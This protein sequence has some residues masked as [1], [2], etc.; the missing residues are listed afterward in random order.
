MKCKLSTLFAFLLVATFAHAQ[1]VISE[2]MYN[3]PETGEDSLEYIELLN[4]SGIQINLQDM[5]FTAG[6]TFTFPNYSL[7]PGQS[8]VV[9]KDS[10]AMKLVF[11]ISSL[12]F[13]GALSNSGEG[14]V[15]SDVQD[16][17]IDE[18]V[19]D[20]A[21]A[22]PLEADEG[23]ASLVLCDPTLNNNEG[24]NWIAARNNT[25]IILNGKEMRCSP[26]LGNAI[27]CNAEPSVFVDVMDFAF[28]PKDITID[29]G[30]TVRWTNKGGTHNINGNQSV[31]PNNPASFGN[32]AP[33]GTLW[34]YDFTFT[35]EG[36][37]QYQCDPHAASGMKGTV[38]VGNPASYPNYTIPLVTTVNQEGVADSV[39]VKC[40]LFGIVHGY[41]LRPGGLQFTLI[42]GQNNGIGVFNGT[43]D[44]GY[45]VKEGDEIKIKGTINQFNGLTQIIADEVSLVSAG[46]NPVNPK[47]VNA[48]NEEDES[49]VIALDGAF[50]Y[51]DPAEWKGDGSSYNVNVTNGSQTFLLR[52]DNDCPLAALP[53]PA[54][55]FN[56]K[57]IVGQFDSSNPYDEGYQIFPRYAADMSPVLATSNLTK[58]DYYFSPNPA[59]S[60]TRVVGEGVILNVNIYDLSGKMVLTIPNSGVLD[61][62][63]LTSGIYNVEIISDNGVN[64]SRLAIQ[65]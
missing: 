6:V 62:S 5:K 49:S 27:S 38:T 31:Y 60:F 32:G 30:T 9:A 22:W 14:I 34:T 13:T 11:G 26:G 37:Y 20:D 44:F 53:A 47:A 25:G 33:S 39:N 23:G 55:P 64:N 17:I 10:T 35:K 42:D 41:N 46:N 43:T 28:N 54:A 3:P 24:A 63:G 61:V 18:V 8:V 12:Q 51:V 29:I 7:A 58:K 50:T 1:V 59:S 48:L 36:L 65:K 57:G 2:I 4:V 15:L 40:Q 52:I 21:G 56:L 45:V 19:Y 16:N